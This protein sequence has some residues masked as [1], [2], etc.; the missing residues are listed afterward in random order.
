[1]ELL[2]TRAQGLPGPFVL[3]SP[4]YAHKYKER[5]FVDWY[6]SQVSV[7]VCVCVCVHLSVYIYIYIFLVELNGTYGY[8]FE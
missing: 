8:V 7:C 4:E 6:I 3:A 5:D 2:L 1:M